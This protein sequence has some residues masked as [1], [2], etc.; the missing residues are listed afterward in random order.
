M[1]DAEDLPLYAC[2]HPHWDVDVPSPI[3][4]LPFFS[5]KAEHDILSGAAAPLFERPLRNPKRKEKP[6]QARQSRGVA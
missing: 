6:D 3:Y 2:D 5:G 1:I 4:D